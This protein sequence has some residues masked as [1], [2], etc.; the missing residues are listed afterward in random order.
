M[1]DGSWPWKS[2]KRQSLF[3][4]S[5][6]KFL[7]KELLGPNSVS[8]GNFISSK[9]FVFEWRFFPPFLRGKGKI[10]KLL[11]SM[12]PIFTMLVRWLD[13]FNTNTWGENS[14]LKV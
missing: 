11:G 2:N 5:L 8:T 7:K 6:S 4:L 13:Y 3:C 12:D 9:R 14:S 1:V 10:V